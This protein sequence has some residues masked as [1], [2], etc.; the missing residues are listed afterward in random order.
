MY[1]QTSS[2]VQFEIGNTRMFSPGWTR[3]LYRSHS[4]GRWAFGSHWPNSSRKEKMRSLARAFSSSRRAPPVQ[5][6]EP[7]P[8]MVSS[9]V[10]AWAALRESVCGLRRR[11]VPFLI[12][13]STEPTIRRSPS[14]ATRASRK[15]ITSSKLW[16]VSMCTSG[17]GNLPGRKAFSARRSSTTESLPPENSRAGFAHS[18]ATSRR[19]WIASDSRASRWRAF[20]SP[21]VPGVSLKV[22]MAMPVPCCGRRSGRHRF[23]TNEFAVHQV[24]AAFLGFRVFPPPAAG[25][26]VFARL[27][28]AGAGLAADR[29]VAALVQAVVGHV[30][31]A[32]VLPHILLRPVGQRVELGHAVGGIVF[33]HG[34]FGA[35]GR[36][37]AALSGDP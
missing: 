20:T 32:D 3:V 23:D 29:R 13:S 2:S 26:D 31:G 27:D 6:A 19:M 9:S 11:T 18:A 5:A 30:V 37:G 25:A 12:E 1:C 22:V 34:Q 35:G 16:P 8:A 10:T 36:L 33:L 17:K 28:R 21:R 24:Q 4:S 15:A 14:S 7:C